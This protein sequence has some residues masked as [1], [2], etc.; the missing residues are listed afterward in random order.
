MDPR[1]I[2]SKTRPLAAFA[3]AAM[4][5]IGF[6]PTLRV[7]FMI[8]DPFLLSAIEAAPEWSWKNFQAELHQGVH[9]QSQSV[10]FRPALSWMVRTEFTLWGRNPLGYHMVTLLFHTANTCLLFLI[11]L[12]LGIPGM[13][14]WVAGAFYAVNPIVIDDFL[15]ST[16]GDSMATFFL[17]A[18]ILFYLRERY[19]TCWLLSFPAVFAKESGAVLPLFLLLFH[20]HL[21]RSKSQALKIGGVFPAI[22]LFAYLRAQSVQSPPG[23][24]LDSSL[25]FLVMAF[26][27]ICLHYVR[28]VLFPVNMETWPPIVPLSHLWP[29]YLAALLAIL[30]ACAK[31]PAGRLYAGWFLVGLLPRV[32][33]MIYSNVLMEKW[34]AVSGP[35]LFLPLAAYATRFWESPRKALRI[36]SSV[37]VAGFLLGWISIAYINVARRG[38]DEK[39]YRWSIRDR[40]RD[41]ANYRLGV[42]LLRSGRPAEA[43]RVLQPLL[44]VLENDADYQNLYALALWDSGD[45]NGAR[46]LMEYLRHRFPNHPA[47]AGNAKRMSA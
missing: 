14:A 36:V 42:I 27:K 4:V 17:F 28:V 22:I 37:V 7:G 16:G 8:D 34:A 41:F 46:H 21:N 47:I 20:V 24:T 45:R 12:T 5:W 18:S 33:A 11:L 29:V 6:W 2:N 39:N 3:L 38:S 10:Y 1:H 26:P 35:G 44:K 40:P 15:A 13:T 30:I 23:F 32:P 25:R 9:R 31:V 43:I 19:W